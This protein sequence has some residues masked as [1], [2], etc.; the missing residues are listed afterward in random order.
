[1]AYSFDE[2]MAYHPDNADVYREIKQFLPK[3]VPFIG[4]GLT[5]FAYF[6]WPD[7]LKTLSGKLANNENAQEITDLINSKHYLDAAQKLED[8]RAPVNLAHDLASIFSADKLEQNREQLRK[9]PISLLPYLFPELILTTNFD[10]TLETVYRESGHP[11]QTVFLP[12]HLELLR[13]LM[14]QGNVCGL[15]KLHGTVTGRLGLIEYERIVFTQTQYDQHYGKRSPLTRELKACFENRMMLFLGCSLE[16]DR[17]MEFL[18]NVIQPGDSYYAIISCES[19]ERDEKVKLLGDKH[20]RVILYEKDRHEAVRVI[21]EHLLEETDPKSYYA[22]PAHA[23]ALKSSS[24]SAR[25][26]YKAEI[27]PFVGRKSELQKLNEFLGDADIAFRWWAIIGPGG[28]GKS[29]LAYEF[30]KRLSPAWKVIYL[31]PNDYSNLSALTEQLTQKT[32]LIADYVQENARVLG[33]WMEQLNEKQR[34]LPIRVLLVE[35]AANNPCA[36]EEDDTSACSVW[37]QQLFADTH[38]DQCLR[39]SCYQDDFLS[40]PNLYDNDLLDI[41]GN[42]A[43][44]IKQINYGNTIILTEEKK[45]ELLQK[46]KTIDPELCRPIYA[47]FLTDAYMEGN[48]PKQWNR[49]HILNYIITRENKRLE[50][51]IRQTIEIERGR[52]K[53]CAACLYLQNVATV[54]QDISLEEIQIVCPEAW[55]VISKMLDDFSLP[56]IMLERI[57]L[58]VKGKIPALCPDLIGEY[59]VYRWITTRSDKAHHFLNAV[60]RKPGFTAAFFERMLRDYEYLLNQTPCYWKLLFPSDFCVSGE[61][62]LLYTALIVNAI[63]LCSSVEECNRL[64]TLLEQSCYTFPERPEITIQFANGLVNLSSKQ[65]EQ[66]TIWTVERIELL[67]EKYPAMMGITVA[68]AKGLFNLSCEQEVM[69]VQQTIRRLEDLVDKHPD[70][71]EIAVAYAK[72]LINLSLN[73]DRIGKKQTIERLGNLVGRYSKSQ[74]IA[75]KFAKGL[76]ILSKDADEKD[77]LRAVD[78]LKQLTKQYSNDQTIKKMYTKSLVNFELSKWSQSAQLNAEVLAIHDRLPM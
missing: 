53:F 74:Q 2:I 72:S 57:G 67:S 76:C 71:T 70:V 15:F 45:K 50:F 51:N 14:R 24:L 78:L 32:L 5:Q 9:E 34:C 37:T 46:L 8:L 65:D 55:N 22:L 69:S 3:L 1:M 16:S 43:A 29:R 4:A 18:Q 39:D 20:I 7:A 54:L 42:Y 40:L 44:A 33:K 31:G 6:S 30:K 59:F 19:S 35:R 52:E 49:E 38:Y 60:W 12:D 61:D 47:M 26:S 13:Q 23:G 41:I 25:F 36:D 11:F 28:S 64:C 77:C 63:G 27:V 58:A 73:Q 68:F 48:D 21:L 10:E 62:S 66:G 17:T 75:V 56:T